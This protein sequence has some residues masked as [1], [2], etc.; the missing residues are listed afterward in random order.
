MC[1]KNNRNE[2][3]I[4]AIAGSVVVGIVTAIL[5]ATGIITLTPAFLWVVFGIAVGYLATVYIASSL[6]RFDTPY[7]ARSL[8]ATFIVGVLGTILISLVLLG[9]TLVAGSA[10]LAV[11]AGLLLLFFSLII[12]SVACIVLSA[13]SYDD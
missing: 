13:Y 12:T 9:V 10:I 2:C 7:S 5:S 6:R 1:R 3:L 4:I 11:L 8:I